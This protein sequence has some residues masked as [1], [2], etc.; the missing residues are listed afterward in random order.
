[1]R[2]SQDVPSGIPSVVAARS[3]HPS[4]EDNSY[5]RDATT[6]EITES[7]GE[8][9]HLKHQPICVSLASQL[10]PHGSDQ[11]HDITVYT[12]ELIIVDA[13][14]DSSGAVVRHRS[15]ACP[16]RAWTEG[17]SKRASPLRTITPVTAE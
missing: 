4:S 13:D 9:I 6:V 12:H 15:D 1:M 2:L 10:T 16:H 5:Q 11:A 17:V 3:D 7:I 14:L 8:T